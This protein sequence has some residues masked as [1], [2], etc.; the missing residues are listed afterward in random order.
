[1]VTW[2]KLPSTP[3]AKKVIEYSIEE[4]RNLNHN[5]V[6]TEHLLLGS[7]REQEGVAAQVLMNLGLRLEDVRKAVLNLLANPPAPKP[8]AMAPVPAGP[9]VPPGPVPDCRFT[10][11]TRTVME[12][13]K[14]EAEHF[15]REM[16]ATEHILCGVLL[17]DEGIA[18]RL[19]QDS[20]V[21]LAKLRTAIEK[22]IA[23]GPY[24]VPVRGMPLTD[25]ARQV[26]SFAA[27]EADRLGEVGISPEHLVLGIL[28][29]REG[30]AAKI[31]AEL[32]VH[33]DNL[34]N[35]IRKALVAARNYLQAPSR[36]DRLD[37]AD[38][39]LVAMEQR[40]IVSAWPA[41]EY[42]MV[43]WSMMAA[44][45]GGLLFG[46]KGM[47]LGPLVGY[48]LGFVGRFTPSVV[49]G[50]LLGATVG[51]A[52]L[53]T[54][55]GT[56]A[57][58]AVGTLLAILIVGCDP[59]RRNAGNQLVIQVAEKDHARA[60]GVIVRHSAG[61]ALPERIFLV[62]EKAAVALRA[63]GIAFSEISKGAELS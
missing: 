61:I 50:S 38:R 17:A 9:P 18:V 23:P 16:I 39:R 7:L 57:G 27:E 28:C 20:G 35:G 36:R 46:I 6:G 44:I 31:L 55:T 40:Y 59:G 56:L 52:H 53:G 29:D 10:Q 12:S 2:G 37:A 63:A 22:N 42:R 32:G 47:V 34:A 60:W 14:R 62:S 11:R 13:A 19:L 5:Y 41:R 48:V 49:A 4:A 33:A 1:M 3:R 30:A 24:G 26:M 54:T 51:A 21:D 43:A 8:E 25:R 15:H 45:G 58:S